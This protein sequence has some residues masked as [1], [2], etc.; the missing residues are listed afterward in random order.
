VTNAK[1][2]Y[3]FGVLAATMLVGVASGFVPM[4]LYAVSE[5]YDWRSPYYMSQTLIAIVAGGA[6]GLATGWVI[7]ACVYDDDAR[8]KVVH[9]LWALLVV[10]LVVFLIIR[11]ALQL[12]RG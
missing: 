10:G 8:R 6:M 7:D 3:P 12:T 5:G 2:R 11:P 9:G 1:R 4:D